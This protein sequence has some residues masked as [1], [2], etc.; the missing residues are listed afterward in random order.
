MA[1]KR[2]DIKRFFNDIN[3]K[4]P[5]NGIQKKI[6]F[7]TNQICIDISNNKGIKKSAAKNY[8]GKDVLYCIRSDF[9][10]RLAADNPIPDE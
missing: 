8:L 2:N 1:I 10:A 5:V 3:C 7:L 9:I 6:S 4:F